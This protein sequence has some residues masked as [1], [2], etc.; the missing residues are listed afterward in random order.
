MR[1]IFETTHHVGT[2]AETNEEKDESYRY[3]DEEPHKNTK[4]Q[5]P[6]AWEQ[7]C[8]GLCEEQERAPV[9]GAQREEWQKNK[10]E[11][12]TGARA[13]PAVGFIPRI[14]RTHS[15]PSLNYDRLFYDRLS[16]NEDHSEFP[17]SETSCPSKKSCFLPFL[18][19]GW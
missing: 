8:L 9:A 16:T 18:C 4:Q 12:E 10:A 3:L 7:S 5:D 11:T 19:E 2:T 14:T 1:T 6:W 17:T 13:Q 15:V